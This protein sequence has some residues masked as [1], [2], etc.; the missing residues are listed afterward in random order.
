MKQ[1]KTTFGLAVLALTLALAA[2]VF[3]HDANSLTTFGHDGA[4]LDG[5]TIEGQKV[6]IEGIVTKRDEDTFTVR[7]SDGT[8]TVVVLTENTNVKIVRRFRADKTAAASDILRGLRLKIEGAGNTEGQI[9]A[10]KIRFEERDLLTAQALESR[11][12]PVESQANSTQTLA[13]SNEKRIA[14]ADE[15]AQRLAGQVEELSGIAAAAQTAAKN[16]QVSADQAQLTADT[17]NERITAL[18]DYAVFRTITVQFRA[19]SASLSRK[20]KEEIDEAVNDLSGGSFKGFAISVVGFADST[21]NKGT[22]RS[23]STRRAESVINYLVTKHNLPL[24][25]VVQPFGYGSLDPVATNQTSDGRSKNRRA[26]IRIL[27]N[28]GITQASL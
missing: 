1:S 17:A 23:L 13:E 28:K 24:Q 11:V 12:S 25:R 15:N 3:G 5:L 8:E 10:A 26:E 27:V 22:N 6:K 18:D 9:V 7:G 21:G 2:T 4:S 19:G 20:A 14:A 16:A